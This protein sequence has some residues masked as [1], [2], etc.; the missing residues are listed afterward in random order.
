MRTRMCA[1]ILAISL[2]LLALPVSTLVQE[3]LPLRP[4]AAGLPG[5]E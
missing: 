2:L 1:I 3:P 4:A 5:R